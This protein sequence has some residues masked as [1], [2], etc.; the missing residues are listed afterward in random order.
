[1]LQL[2]AGGADQSLL[3]LYKDGGVRR[4]KARQGQAGQ[5]R[6]AAA[7]TPAH[8]R[9]YLTGQRT[10]DYIRCALMLATEPCSTLYSPKL[11]HIPQVSARFDAAAAQQ[12]PA[13]RV[14]TPRE[15][16][17]KSAEP[18]RRSPRLRHDAHTQSRDSRPKANGKQERPR[19][20]ARATERPVIASLG[21][22]GADSG[23]AGKQRS[24]QSLRLSTTTASSSL[25]LSSRNKQHFLLRPCKGS[26]NR[27]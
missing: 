7:P 21:M 5:R 19:H 27:S 9:W 15:D 12:D 24:P 8:P 13:W 16:G 18:G 20:E 17:T 10:R 1:M 6:H 2:F 23:I 22:G 26:A 11:L 3:F 25:Q 4:C 14:R